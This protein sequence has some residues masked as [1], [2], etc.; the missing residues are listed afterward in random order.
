MKWNLML[1]QLINHNEDIK[2]LIDDGYEVEINGGYIFTHHIPYVKSNLE[3]AYAT[4]FCAYNKQGLLLSPINHTIYYIGGTPCDRKGKALENIFHSENIKVTNE[5][6]ADRMF[7][8]RPN[9]RDYK[10]FYEKFKTYIAILSSEAIAIDPDVTAIT[11]KPIKLTEENSPLQYLDTNSTRANIEFLNQKFYNQKIAI[12][13]LGGTGS[14][15]LDLISKIPVKEVHLYDNDEFN[16]HNA[17]RSPGAASF[18]ILNQRLSKVNYYSSIYSNMHKSIMP[19][20]E[21]VD[22]SNISQLLQYDF[23]FICIDSNKSRLKIC[24][25]L[26]EKN[27][28]FIDVGL[29]VNLIDDALSGSIRVSFPFGQNINIIQNHCGKGNL[30]DDLYASNIQIAELNALNATLA[31]IKWKCELGYYRCLQEYHTLSYILSMNKI[32]YE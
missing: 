6:T 1:Q 15:I 19:H 28:K 23:V 29:G 8:S 32:I 16:T 11:Y 21:F 27:I 2:R 22:D 18:E 5:I 26:I 4:L 25:F 3:I 12:V 20:N 9:N 13:G 14:Y 24:S 17:F 30:E 7:S 31:V 10:G